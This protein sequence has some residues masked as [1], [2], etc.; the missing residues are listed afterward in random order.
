MCIYTGPYGLEYELCLIDVWRGKGGDW[1]DA[2]A[3]CEC[4]GQMISEREGLGRALGANK[5]IA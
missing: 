4:L 3:G 5:G 2:V 1:V